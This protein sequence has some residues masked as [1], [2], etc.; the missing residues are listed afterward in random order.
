MKHGL[1][2]PVPFSPG[3]RGRGR[4]RCDRAS[5]GEQQPRPILSEELPLV[6]PGARRADPAPCAAGPLDWPF[7]L[8]WT[9]MRRR[10]PEL[11]FSGSHLQPVPDDAGVAG[12][13]DVATPQANP[14]QSRTA[15]VLGLHCRGL[16]SGL[17]Q[18]TLMGTSRRHARRLVLGRVPR[19]MAQQH[20]LLGQWAR[21]GA[22]PGA[23]RPWQPPA[24]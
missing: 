19:V 23:G 1:A 14:R 7:S 11:P 5:G 9:C 8:I 15:S 4:P 16:V 3:S 2:H 24:F 17:D 20:L 18:G 10:L 21:E 6:L 22:P 13:S 12:T